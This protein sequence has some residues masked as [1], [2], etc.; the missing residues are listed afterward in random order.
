MRNSGEV[1]NRMKYQF[2]L[3]NIKEKGY[4]IGNVK[5]K[6]LY[7]VAETAEE[8]YKMS[9]KALAQIDGITD[10]EIAYIIDSRR[11]WDLEKEWEVFLEKGI[12]FVTIESL[13][14]PQKLR[15]ISN[16]PYCLF[17]LGR[18]P[19]GKKKSVAIVG[20]R[21]RSAYG[22][23]VSR[24]LGQSL[25]QNG[26]QV[27]SGMAKGIDTDGHLGALEGNGDTYA[28]LGC[29]VD[30]CYPKSNRYLYEELMKKGGILSEYAPGTPPDAGRFPPR[31]RIISGLSDKVVVIE[32]R[33]KSGSLITA[34]FALEQGKDVYAL[35][36]RITDALSE[37]C[38]ALIKQGAGAITGI[39]DFVSE[40]TISGETSC[41]QIDFRQILLEKDESLVY[42]LLDFCPVGIGTLM[43]KVPYQ[44]MQL[45][46]ILERLEKKEMIRET[47][48]NYFIRTL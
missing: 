34:D 47:V 8:I 42:S 30:V 44:L 7:D 19:D 16:A 11:T 26:I 17:Y 39:N 14:F 23:E 1:W 29:G 33:K 40:L 31:N 3:S 21:G 12:G 4:G 36:G 32:A 22:S 2:W 35:P 41:T 48:P 38:N 9:E 46:E 15:T 13:E 37:G 25:A 5:I 28:V 24:R 20:A 6:H 27:I 10:K 43:E 45:V 18:L